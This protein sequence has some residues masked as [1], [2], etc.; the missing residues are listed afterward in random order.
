M[1]FSL[2]SILA[3]SLIVFSAFYF[4]TCKIG[5]PQRTTYRT[6]KSLDDL[7]NWTQIIANHPMIDSFEILNTGAVKVPLNG[8]LNIDKLP[9]DHKMDETLWVD[10][11]AF[12]FHH[13]KKGWFLIDTG[14]DS[15]FQ[16]KGNIKGL[17]SGKFIK[18]TRQT[19]GQN[20]GQQLRA[21]NKDLKGI[22]LTHLHGDH[23]AGLPEIDKSIPIHVG[24][25]EKYFNYPLIYKSNH[26]DGAD[27]LIELDWALGQ[28]I[29]PM[30]SVL[31]IFEDGSFLALYT[32]GHSN[33]HLSYFLNTAN[34]PILLTGDA[35]H[36]RYGFENGIEPGW[37]NDQSL[38]L[39]SLNQLRQLAKDYPT[40][41]VIFGHQQ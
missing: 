35:S 7:K 6:T 12:L 36:T 40:I 13:Q 8:M 37:V 25:F 33:S 9:A 4:I 32:P 21:R 23:S 28:N 34:G 1:K 2:R 10:V 27:T 31:D 19:P 24:K 22:F 16:A 5:Q 29:Q 14:L 30:E 17:L 41:K 11:Y 18:D 38:A 3:F 15:S 20:I 26:L 39:N